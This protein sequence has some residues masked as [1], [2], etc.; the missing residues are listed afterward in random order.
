LMPDAVLK[1]FSR[2][3]NKLDLRKPLKP[4]VHFLFQHAGTRRSRTTSSTSS[5]SSTSGRKV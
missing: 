4:S 2:T 5:T 3:R 1:V